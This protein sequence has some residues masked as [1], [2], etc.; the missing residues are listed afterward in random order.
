MLS[1]L[2]V[3]VLAAACSWALTGM[4][5]GR[6][7]ARGRLDMPNERSSH[8]VPT[9]RGG[10]LAIAAVVLGG[11]TLAAFRGWLPLDVT[12]A[13]VGGGLLI[14]AIGWLDDW[15]NLNA[16]PRLLVHAIAAVWA[17]AWLGGMPRLQVGAGTV[18]LG[19]FGSV[20]A[21]LGIVW[22]TN[23]YNFMDG[24]DGIAG[25]Q[26]VAA[27][28]AG[29][30]LLMLAGAPD[31]A[32]AAVLVGAASA[33]FLV[34]NWAPAR[35]FMGDVGSGLLGFLFA[36]LAVASEN[37]GAV[38]LLAWTLLLGVFVVDATL[39][40]LRRALEGEPVFAA[41]RKHA[42]QRAVQAG[43]SHARVSTLV[44]VLNVALAPLALLALR[45]PDYLLAI[46]G[47]G[48]GALVL[49]QIGVLTWAEAA[50]A[51]RETPAVLPPVRTGE[52]PARPPYRAPST[53]M[54][55]SGRRADRTA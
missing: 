12:M 11:M 13:L 48:I 42:Y 52:A 43:M 33:G 18:G 27:G 29:G 14:A 37:R 24:I 53:A 25:V 36:V 2:A 32:G 6:M 46:T 26:A 3:V 34:W 38:P 39:T 9:P 54:L 40:L 55:N 44:L 21:V 19:L 49:M 47:A 15:F 31:L 20:L 45:L 7:L 16:W 22:A 23:F 4:V 35:I 28:I 41:H 30:V 1:L 17:L 5:R 51:A 8:A 50:R 10:G